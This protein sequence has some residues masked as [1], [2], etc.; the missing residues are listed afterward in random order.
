MSMISESH[1]VHPLQDVM[2]I[3]YHP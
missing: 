1:C 3:I 2:N